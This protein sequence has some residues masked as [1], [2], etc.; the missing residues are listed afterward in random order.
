MKIT[1]KTK[2][3]D[4]EVEARSCGVPGL[5]VHHLYGLKD[6]WG[7]THK[8]SGYLVCG[9]S[10]PT[11]ADAIELAQRFKGLVDWTVSQEGL[12]DM[13]K[14]GAA[15]RATIYPG[16]YG[17]PEPRESIVESLLPEGWEL[18]GDDF[19]GLL[20]CPHG[21]EIEMDGVCSRGCV[22]PLRT[23]GMI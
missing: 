16:L 11:R 18:N 21:D 7:I 3:G 6:R 15:V 23:A 9:E 8:A 1:I 20:V 5:V 2:Q 14:L 17:V 13:G 10:L 19:D 22:S 12:G 4:R